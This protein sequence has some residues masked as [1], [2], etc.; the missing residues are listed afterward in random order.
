LTATPATRR[1]GTNNYYTQDGYGGGSGSPTAVSPSANC[2]GG[3][4]V[5][6]ADNTQPGVAAVQDYL[7]CLKPKIKH[8]CEKGYYYLVNNY[9][10]GYFGDGSNAYTDANKNNYVFTIPPSSLRNIGDELIDNSVSWAYFG[11]QWKFYK[12]DKYD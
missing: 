1:P 2:G 5:T 3:S 8:N 10:P 6:C 12:N 9:N 4:Y 7:K 11:D